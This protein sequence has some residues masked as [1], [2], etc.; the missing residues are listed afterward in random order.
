MP[1]TLSAGRKIIATTTMPRPPNH[2]SMPRQ[3]RVPAGRWSRPTNTVEP[4]VV[5]ADIASNSASVKLARGAPNQKGSAPNSGKTT[6]MPV[7]SRNPCCRPSGRRSRRE[8][9]SA[10]STPID[11]GQDRGRREDRRR[12]CAGHEIGQHRQR[13]RRAERGH[14]PADQVAD[15]ADVDHARDRCPQRSGLSSRGPGPA[16]DRAVRRAR[17]RAGAGCRRAARRRSAA[18]RAAACRR[19]AISLIA[20]SAIIEPITPGSAPMTPAT[21]QLGTSAGSGGSGNRHA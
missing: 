5:I 9:A 14:Q 12:C 4:V 20:S 17:R 8:Q 15:G 16:A 2:C 10:I 18:R 19:A 7:V 3:S 11:H 1:P 6:Q 13:H 21:A